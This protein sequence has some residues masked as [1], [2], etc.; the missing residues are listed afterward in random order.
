ML[1]YE[2]GIT[3]I[4]PNSEN[5]FVTDKQFAKLKSKFSKIVL[6]YDND[7]PGIKNMNKIH[8][9]YPE[10]TTVFIPRKY[11]AKDISDFRKKYGKNKTQELINEA[12]TYYGKKENWGI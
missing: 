3:A 2:F 4:A 5:L 11:A 10:L 6:F 12:L 9:Q 8:K 1:L 7:L